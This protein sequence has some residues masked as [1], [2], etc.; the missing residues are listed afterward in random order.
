MRVRGPFGLML[1]IIL[2]SGTS[3]LAGDY[4]RS[5]AV[6]APSTMTLA[7]SH[8]SARPREPREIRGD[9]GDRR[10]LAWILL[11]MKDGKGAR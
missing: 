11:L 7:P 1:T 4:T 5:V 6:D 8:S 3:A 10:M 2:V 9:L